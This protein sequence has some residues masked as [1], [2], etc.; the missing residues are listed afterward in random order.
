MLSNTATRYGAAARFFHWSIALLIL[1]DIALG[2]IGE[3]TPRTAETAERL[4]TLYSVHKTIGIAVLGLAVLRILWAFVQPK[5]VPVHPERKAETVLAEV[6]H[7]M[8][9]G[10]ILIM[11]LSGWVMHA[12]ESGFA[13]ILWPF[14]QNLPFVPKSEDVAHMAGAVHGLS[15]WVIYITVALHILGA[16][17]HAV[18][19]KDGVLARMLRGTEAGGEGE[20]HAS[21]L[22]PVLA[23]V[24]WIAVVSFPFVA[25][26]QKHEEGASA[27]PME[28]VEIASELPAW[29]V[30]QGG[31]TISVTQ[32][33]APVEGS[34][35]NWTAAIAYD[36]ETGT[37][38]V[39]VSI[40]TTSLSLGTVTQQAQG[41]EFFDT[42]T[43]ATATF[44]GE[45]TRLEGTSHEAVG[46]LTLVGQT[47]PVT[48]AFDLT[49][50]GDRATMSGTTALDRRDFGMGAGYEDEGTVGF[51][52]EV[53][54]ELTAVRQ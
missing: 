2:L 27:A 40:D 33:G 51:G 10:A 35:A 4:Q 19:E 3:N 41:P 17:K 13:P 43:Y 21:A 47:V 12:A 18:I 24:L 42:E 14:G 23:A 7:W 20:S 25:P 52:V 9:Y 34:F 30:E 6:I 16:L 48:L 39:T 11:P 44:T 54:T 36:D 29:A 49:V 38:E 32:M 26:A 8:L 37:G 31:L 1:A 15:A 28:Q 46:T 5:P 53:A 50:D 45:I 22:P